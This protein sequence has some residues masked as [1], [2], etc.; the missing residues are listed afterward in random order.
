MPCRHAVSPLSGA[1][2]S[3]EIRPVNEARTTGKVPRRR[4]L[5]LLVGSLLLLVAGVL[6]AFDPAATGFYPPCVFHKLTGLHCPGCGSLRATHHLLQGHLGEALSM[7]I[8]L[9]MLG[10]VLAGY[11]IQELRGKTVWISRKV[12]IAILTLVLLFRLIF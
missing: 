7:N 9:F 10:P 2:N 4:W 1:T 5:A 8:L 12:G 6:H 3:D 11:A